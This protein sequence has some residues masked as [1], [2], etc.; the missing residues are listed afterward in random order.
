LPPDGKR[1]SRPDTWYNWIVRTATETATANKQTLKEIDTMGKTKTTQQKKSSSS[2][3]PRSPAFTVTGTDLNLDVAW[4]APIIND[5]KQISHSTASIQID[6]D[7][8][9]T[10]PQ[11]RGYTPREEEFMSDLRAG[12][13]GGSDIEVQVTRVPTG[14]IWCDLSL[15]PHQ[16]A[17]A[18]G[19]PPVARRFAAARRYGKTGEL[20]SSF[21]E[22]LWEREL[23]NN[24]TLRS[25]LQK[26]RHAAG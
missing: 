19:C 16:M 25:D 26:L 13:R 20:F 17:T 1:A 14:W 3:I 24:A 21:D 2:S 6:F 4:C 8:G 7:G 11:P 23:Q 5:Y 9:T 12:E 18:V 10:P 22:M 15:T